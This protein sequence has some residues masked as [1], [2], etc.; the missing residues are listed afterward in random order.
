MINACAQ[1]NHEPPLATVSRARRARGKRNHLAGLAAEERV[2]QVYRRAGY[3]L[4][5]TRWRGAAGEIDLIFD[6]ADD[7]I[8]VEV[9]SS[10]SLDT[11]L[12]MVTPTKAARLLNAATEYLGT[13]P[14]G[15]ATFSRIDVA[16]MDAIGEVT[17][18][19][20]AIGH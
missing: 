8:F 16:C 11:A 3:R 10:S 12:A 19:E 17:V 1:S 14:R 13:T 9:K 15:L 2:A 6:G 7:L 20:N 18:L 5:E 4:R